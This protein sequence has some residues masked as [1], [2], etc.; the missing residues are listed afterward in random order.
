MSSAAT[1]REGE[2][3]ASAGPPHRSRNCPSIPPMSPRAV[4][5]WIAAAYMLVILT[6]LWATGVLP[7]PSP[8][9]G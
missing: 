3:R 8:P 6:S 2:A 7:P 5:L 1:T 9:L 4:W